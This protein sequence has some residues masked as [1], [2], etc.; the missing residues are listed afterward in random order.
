MKHT[1]KFG[2]LFLAYVLLISNCAWTEGTQITKKGFTIDTLDDG[3]EMH[4]YYDFNAAEVYLLVKDGILHM[5]DRKTIEPPI[6]ITP[7]PTSS[8]ITMIFFNNHKSLFPQDINVE[9]YYLEQK[10]HTFEFKQS[11]GTE[12]IPETYLQKEG[13]YR[14]AATFSMKEY[15][16]NTSFTGYDGQSTYIAPF[17]V[18]KIK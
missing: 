5:I 13:V 10:I 18:T 11:K 3:R 15:E 1:L 16:G 17:M 9:L 4:T 2:L 7:N 12:V 8:S 14:V 6:N